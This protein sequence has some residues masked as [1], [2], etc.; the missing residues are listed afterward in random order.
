MNDVLDVM[1]RKVHF[2][3]VGATDGDG[4]LV[5]IFTDGDIRR[6]LA[7]GVDLMNS[8]L[9]DVMGKSPKTVAPDTLATSATLAMNEKKIQVFFAVDADDRPVG[10]LS[11][12]DLLKA[13]V[14]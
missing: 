9:R 1:G 14:A 7:D 12:H 8:K 13:G 5:G 6:K 4:R 2:G 10:I 11:F 3:C